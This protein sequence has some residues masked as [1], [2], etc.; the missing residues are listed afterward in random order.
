ME[1]TEYITLF[2]AT[3]KD[4][5]LTLFSEFR[6]YKSWQWNH[7]EDHVD[8]KQGHWEDETHSKVEP[9]VE[10]NGELDAVETVLLLQVVG[11]V[12]VPCKQKYLVLKFCWKRHACEWGIHI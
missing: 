4:N 11:S 5:L 6:L 1:T 7:V 2:K 12:H 9:S 10:K 3:N 8:D